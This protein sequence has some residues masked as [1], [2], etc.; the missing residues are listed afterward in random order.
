MRAQHANNRVTETDKA[1]EKLIFDAV[2][3]SFPE[4]QL[5]GEESSADAGS[6]AALTDAPTWIVD[7]VDGTTNFVH[8]FPMTCVSIAF[9][10]GTKVDWLHAI[11]VL[12]NVYVRY[13]YIY[14]NITPLFQ[15]CEQERFFFSDPVEKKEK[16]DKTKYCCTHSFGGALH[17]LLASVLLGTKSLIW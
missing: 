16:K 14:T 6:I 1:N 9:G 4:D 7:P 10:R 17:G 3:N 11:C 15:C 12:V 8:G 13:V 5:I 2:R